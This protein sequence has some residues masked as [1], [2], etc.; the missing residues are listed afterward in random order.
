MMNGQLIPK[1]RRFKSGRGDTFYSNTN[2]KTEQICKNCRKDVHCCIFKDSDGF[3]F[4]G[5][6]DA[7]RIKKT[8]EKDYKEFLDYSPLSKKTIKEL[9][10]DDPLVEGG[11]RCAQL[12]K[13]RILRLKTK[14]DKRCIFL[15]DGGNCDIYSVRPNICRI[16][17]YWAIKLDNKQLKVIPHDNPSRCMIVKKK[18]V[19]KKEIIKLFKEVEK[20]TAYYHKNIKE[21]VKKENIASKNR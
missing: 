4:V 8:I 1:G 9:K 14:K 11:M 19:D 16:Y 20:E 18:N 2:M 17:P 6:N 3:T 12:D 5:I 7:K 10:E 13:D 21:F 15:N